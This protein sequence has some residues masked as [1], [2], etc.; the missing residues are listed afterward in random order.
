[1]GKL[2]GILCVIACKLFYMALGVVLFFMVLFSPFL[3]CY[4]KTVN[5]TP[6]ATFEGLPKREYFSVYVNKAVLAPDGKASLEYAFPDKPKGS[7]V[8]PEKVK[9]IAVYDKYRGKT[10]DE[11][12]KME[13][14]GKLFSG[15]RNGRF[16][17]IGIENGK[18]KNFSAGD[19]LVDDEP[20]LLALMFDVASEKC[21][22]LV[23]VH[24]S[25]HMYTVT[26]SVLRER[27]GEPAAQ[28]NIAKSIRVSVW[29]GKD[30]MLMWYEKDGAACGMV[31]SDNLFAQ[32]QENGLERR[33]KQDGIK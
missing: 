4:Y 1:M 13:P 33:R 9:G 31:M 29:S 2:F 32:T 11:A 15:D 27:L 10:I 19:Y 3:Y 18:W 24:P 5:F 26:G 22:G 21:V 16:I 12:R 14:S 7:Y 23:T 6:V 20:D 8:Y 25:E 30:V 28:V 17:G